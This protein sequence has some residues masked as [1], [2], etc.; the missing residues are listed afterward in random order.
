M[1]KVAR[2]IAYAH[3]CG[4]IHRD[5]K[6]ANVLLDQRG[7]PR[8]TDFGLVKKVQGDS[9]LTGSGQIMGTP[10]YMAPEQARGSRGKIGPAADTYSLGATLYALVTGRPPFQAATAIDTMLMVIN[11]EPVPPRRLNASLPRDLE[12]ICLKCLEKDPR[13]RYS[14]AEALAEDLDRWLRGEPILRGPSQSPSGRP[15]GRGEAGDCIAERSPAD[16]CH[17]RDLR[18]RL[19]GE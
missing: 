3:R 8:V 18:N 4:V 19:E 9:N 12:T 5:L 13:T 2:A 14:S 6:P 16:G 10:S 11:D 15:N 1:V 17:L 7:N